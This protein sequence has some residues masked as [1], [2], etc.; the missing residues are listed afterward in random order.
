MENME[1]ENPTD[2]RVRIATWVILAALIVFWV[3]VLS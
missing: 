1:L 2:K 3:L